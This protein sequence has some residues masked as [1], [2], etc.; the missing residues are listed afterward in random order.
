[1]LAFARVLKS[2]MLPLLE[3]PA[4]GAGGSERLA[5]ARRAAPPGE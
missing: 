5:A 1:V 3:P 4:D 2:P